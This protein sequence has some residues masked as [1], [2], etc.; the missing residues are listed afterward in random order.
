MNLYDQVWQIPG[1]CANGLDRAREVLDELTEQCKDNH[2]LNV[3]DVGCGRGHVVQHLRGVGIHACGI[4]PFL[5]ERAPHCLRG[6]LATITY[7]GTVDAITCFDVL[8]HLTVDS[9][10]GLLDTM[11]RITP[12]VCLAIAN[13]HDLHDVPGR[14]LVDL[15]LTHKP[16]QEWEKIVFSHFDNVRVQLL[17]YPDQFFIWAGDWKC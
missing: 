3:L 12:R 17:P 9:A 7:F 5:P 2:W 6:D 14:G 13:M 8:E 16:Q 1:Y 15:H 10:H 11:M 4:D